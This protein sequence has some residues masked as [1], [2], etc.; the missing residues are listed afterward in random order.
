MYY[1]RTDIIE[2][3]DPAK[4]NNSKECIICHLWLFGHWFEFQ[5]FVCNGC[6]D[7]TILIFNKND[8]AIMA[9]KMLVLVVLFIT[10]SN[11]SKNLVL[12]ERGYI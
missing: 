12:E 1:D 10:I 6:H 8:I 3:I 5:H 7:L 4:S 9:V 11:V 2:G